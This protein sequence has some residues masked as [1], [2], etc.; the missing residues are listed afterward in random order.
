MFCGERTPGGNETP[1]YH[2]LPLFTLLFSPP[3]PNPLFS[4]CQLQ[5][6]IPH[7]SPSFS[8]ITNQSNRKASSFTHE[9]P[10]LPSLVPHPI[11]KK[12]PTHF[13]GAQTFPSPSVML[14]SQPSPRASDSYSHLTRFHASIDRVRSMYTHK[15]SWMLSRIDF[16]TQKTKG[17]CV[18]KAKESCLDPISNQIY[19][20]VV[21][22]V[23]STYRVRARA[24]R[25]I[26]QK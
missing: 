7:P 5:A 14:L 4:K 19:L 3:T 26:L 2:S 17:F 12:K 6:P 21:R 1:S 16:E 9:K 8:P 10:V 13:H 11:S 22:I 18:Y 15:T 25:R 24:R 23:V 20:T